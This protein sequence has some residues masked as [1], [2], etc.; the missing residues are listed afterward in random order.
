M[1]H[2]YQNIEG[3]FSYEY[4]YKDLVEQAEEDS[5]FVE[6][7]SFKGRSTAFM[8][9]EIANSG[10]KIRFQCIDPMKAIG[11][12]ED[13]AKI[14]PQ[15]WEGYSSEAFHKR[16]ESVK[17][18]YTLHQMPSDQAVNMYKDNSIDFIMIDGDHSYEAVKRDIENFLPKMRSGGLMAGDDAF[19]EEVQRAVADAAKGLEYHINGIHFFISIP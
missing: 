12:Y 5:L 19:A 10:K 7:G 2:F 11:H 18:F 8:A 4:I 3:W 1:E 13:A 6:I 17:D 16:L 15:E 9:V 14:N